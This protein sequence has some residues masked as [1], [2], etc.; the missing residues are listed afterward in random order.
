MF[1]GAL[2]PGL[3]LVGLFM[4]YILIVAFF[5]PKI[6]PSVPFEGKYDRKFAV[7]VLLALIPP[8]ALIFVVL[9]SIITGIATVNQAAPGAVGAMVMAGYRL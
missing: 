9:G 2:L 6:A 8:L 3:V 7:T 5:K 4:A 1:M